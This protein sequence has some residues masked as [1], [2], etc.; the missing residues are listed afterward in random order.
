MNG[1]G[2]YRYT[3]FRGACIW[4]SLPGVL[5]KSGAGLLEWL[6]GFLLLFLVLSFMAAP[7]SPTSLIFRSSP[8]VFVSQVCEFYSYFQLVGS[9][10][11]PG[12]IPNAL[13]TLTLVQL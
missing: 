11:K 4:Y 5:S 10:L 1:L 8:S 12:F 6:A 3:F 2:R 13:M 7:M 9:K